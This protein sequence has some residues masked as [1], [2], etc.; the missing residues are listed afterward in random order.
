LSF[1]MF[2]SNICNAFVGLSFRLS[3]FIAF[4]I[5]AEVKVAQ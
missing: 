2:S 5:N 4:T 1:G 3:F